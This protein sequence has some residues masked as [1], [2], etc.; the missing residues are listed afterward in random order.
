MKSDPCPPTSPPLRRAVVFPGQ[1]SQTPGMGRALLERWPELRGRLQELSGAAGADLEALLCAEAPSSDPVDVHLAMV[2]Y[3]ILAW[4]G[5]ARHENFA[6]AM[7]AGHSLGEITA[8]ACAGALSAADALGLAAARGR[9]MAEA[10]EARPGS[11]CALVGAPIDEMQDAIHAWIRAAGTE[12]ELWIVNLNGP[13]QLVAA[14]R[15]ETLQA[16]TE[17]MRARGLNA[18]PLATAGA[19]HT[20][21][22]HDA[23]KRLHAWCD[24]LSLQPPSLPV[25]SSMTGRL[26]TQAS[27]AGVHF[28]L[29][30]VNP[31]RW[32]AVMQC[33]QRARIEELIEAGPGDVL[34]RLASGCRDWPVRACPATAWPEPRKEAVQT[35]A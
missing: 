20:P 15:G 10:C 32:L 2:S 17:A 13:R 28:A 14:G 25:V 23:A 34:S 7:V 11:M 30:L 4:E 6:P 26:L 9:F 24:N 22:M 1:G 18:V 31:V 5:L 3:G 8:L 21:Y 19:F 35:P 12:H 16:M 33:M 29:Q 27:D